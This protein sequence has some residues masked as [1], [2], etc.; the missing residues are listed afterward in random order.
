MEDVEFGESIA[1]PKSSLFVGKQEFRLGVDSPKE[2]ANHDLQFELVMTVG[3][4]VELRSTGWRIRQGYV[5]TP[6]R[7]IHG[8]R[9]VPMHFFETERMTEYVYRM[10]AKAWG[11]AYPQVFGGICKES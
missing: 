4:S 7:Q 5:L 1:K 3:E 10:C 2:L 8:G 9:Y 6:S 11:E